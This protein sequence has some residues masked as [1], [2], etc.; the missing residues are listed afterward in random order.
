MTTQIYNPQ[1][2]IVKELRKI[3]DEISNEIKDMTFEEERAYLD[4]L[5]DQQSTA[6]KKYSVKKIRQK[7]E[8]AYMPWTQEDDSK[9]EIL[10]CEGKPIKELAQVFGRNEGAINSRI[11]KLELREKYDK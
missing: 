3:R 11:K 9:L 6:Q 1:Q 10:F 4:N 8:Q 7:H 2:N 5:L